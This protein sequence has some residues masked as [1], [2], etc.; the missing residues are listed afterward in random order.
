MFLFV[1]AEAF[2]TFD[3]LAERLESALKY[4]RRLVRKGDIL[5]LLRSRFPA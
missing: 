4:R 3:H 2:G 1:G 5:C